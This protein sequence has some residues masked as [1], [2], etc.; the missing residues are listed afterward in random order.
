MVAEGLMKPE[1]RAVSKGFSAVSRCVEI[2]SA[3]HITL[4]RTMNQKQQRFQT[5]PKEI[6]CESQEAFLT[7]S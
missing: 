4:L 3:D 2:R 5:S 1:K 7:L 6:A